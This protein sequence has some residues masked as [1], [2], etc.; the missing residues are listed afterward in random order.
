LANLAKGKA[1]RLFRIAENQNWKCP[2]C[3]EPLFNGEEIETHHIVPVA[4]GGTDDME[5]RRAPTQA[6]SDHKQVHKTQ[7]KSRLK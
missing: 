4:E 2:E 7:V 6:V 3:G 5:N 1:S